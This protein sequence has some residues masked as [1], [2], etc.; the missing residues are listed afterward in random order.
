MPFGDI[1]ID[2]QLSHAARDRGGVAPSR[3]AVARAQAQRTRAEL[4]RSAA[5]DRRVFAIWRSGDGLKWMRRLLSEG[6]ALDR[7]HRQRV[8]SG[9]DPE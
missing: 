2:L 9:S 1:D 7:E 3:M 6:A 8:S 4:L 5:P